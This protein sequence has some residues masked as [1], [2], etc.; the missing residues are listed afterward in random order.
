MT[1]TTAEIARL[2]ITAAKA[3]G[4]AATQADAVTR[5]V[6]LTLA[7]ECEAAANALGTAPTT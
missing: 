2:R 7:D 5:G 6:L 3:S 1:D 4:L